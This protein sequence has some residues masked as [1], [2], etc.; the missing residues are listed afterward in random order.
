LSRFTRKPV[1][2][3]LFRNGRILRLLRNPEGLPDWKS[4]FQVK[5]LECRWLE[6]EDVSRKGAKSAKENAKKKL[7]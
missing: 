1:A 6:P 3:F 5:F 2:P 7:H 4:Q